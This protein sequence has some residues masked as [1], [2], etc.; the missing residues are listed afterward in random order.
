MLYPFRDGVDGNQYFRRLAGCVHRL[1][2][3]LQA[4]E[5]DQRDSDTKR[6]Q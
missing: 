5:T 2:H 6:D 4:I 3:T 1:L